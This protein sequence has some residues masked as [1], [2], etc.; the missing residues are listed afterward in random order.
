MR[1]ELTITGR[2]AAQGVIA[3]VRA[4][5]DGIRRDLGS[6]RTRA[7]GLVGEFEKIPRRMI[8][9]GGAALAF[10]ATV[11]LVRRAWGEVNAE[12]ERSG[13]LLRQTQDA[14]R[15][16]LTM[17][18][19]GARAGKQEAL[20]AQARESPATFAQIAAGEAAVRSMQAATG[21]SDEAAQVLMRHAEVTQRLRGGEMA[22]I[23]GTTGKM[24][25]MFP[26]IGPTGI[27]NIYSYLQT[28]AGFQGTQLQEFMGQLSKGLGPGKAAGVDPA[29]VFGLMA[30]MSG[31]EGSPSRAAEGVG[32]LIKKLYTP[33]V[34]KKLGVTEQQLE[35]MEFEQRMALALK[36]SEGRGPGFW[37]QMFGE[38]YGGRIAVTIGNEEGRAQ[39]ARHRA[40]VREAAGQPGLVAGT[41][42]SDRLATEWRFRKAERLAR[43][44]EREELRVLTRENVD[45]TEAR[46]VAK[47]VLGQVYPESSISHVTA[48]ALGAGRHWLDVHTRGVEAAESTMR[49]HL[50]H[51]ALPFLV[52]KR[53]ADIILENAGAAIDR[54][55]ENARRLEPDPTGAEPLPVLAL[56]TGV[57]PPK[58]VSRGPKPGDQPVYINTD[59]EGSD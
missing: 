58:P 56:E 14:S 29:L 39:T 4:G 2:N 17:L 44:A 27:G 21:F 31:I 7:S 51:N 18:P 28:A 43:L 57:P 34:A 46:A 41:D 20:I 36:K 42:Y 37:T 23:G 12:I 33:G 10:G 48:R 54:A 25:G 40:A 32:G 47:D 15:E 53:R 26:E 45:K 3:E 52:S 59:P 13:M 6:Q 16:L 1:E 9:A 50:A 8:V 22:Q 35:P 11:G 55:Y 49:T 30:T 19:A 5:L 24:L 38:D